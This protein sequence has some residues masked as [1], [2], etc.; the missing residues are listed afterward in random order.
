MSLSS[1]SSRVSLTY[2][3]SDTESSHAIDRDA[4]ASRRSGNSDSLSNDPSNT[5]NIAATAT[6]TT[7]SAVTKLP[8]ASA[9]VR[10]PRMRARAHVLDECPDEIR[11]YFLHVGILNRKETKKKKLATL[12]NYSLV[13]TAHYHEV[14]SV[15]N[16]DEGREMSLLHTRHA[17]PH[18]VAKK[19]LHVGWEKDIVRRTQK[20]VATYKQVY[21][22]LE[23][24]SARRK[25]RGARTLVVNELFNAD[26]LSYLHLNCSLN[27]SPPAESSYRRVPRN[28]GEIAKYKLSKFASKL[29]AKSTTLLKG[30][31]IDDGP[32]LAVVLGERLQKLAEQGEKQPTIIL[33]FRDQDFK[34]AVAPLM[35]KLA[36]LAKSLTGLQELDLSNSRKM[37]GAEGA[38]RSQFAWGLDRLLR[39]TSS[40]RVIKLTSLWFCQQ[41]CQYLSEG[42]RYNTSLTYMDLSQT[43]LAVDGL[44]QLCKALEA[45]ST[46][47]KL[48]LVE[49]GL[50]DH[51]ADS[52]LKL[53]KANQTLTIDLSGN[54]NISPDHLI[55]KMEDRVI[56]RDNFWSNLPDDA[57]SD[58]TESS[59]ISEVVDSSDASDNADGS[60][61]FNDP[62]H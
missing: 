17:F 25:A 42:L 31:Q 6:S 55:F 14:V 34:T 26:G 53:L 38:L 27:S 49:C 40:L 61:G 13:C 50:R 56:V 51:H 44:D 16:K 18:L 5:T 9:L 59:V 52:L 60:L 30:P 19:G 4:A 35:E 7:T 1:T 33:E 28:V 46:L 48:D 37:I 23:N 43:A 36:S 62:D 10:A 11:T 15:L 3:T 57:P 24:I 20:F 2:S 54:F 39:A 21:V 41:G 58:T 32:Q 8:N 29:A 47:Q 12:R 45:N 22:D